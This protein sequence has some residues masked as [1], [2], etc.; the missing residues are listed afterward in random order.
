[1]SLPLLL[2]ILFIII[3]ALALLVLWAICKAG[4]DAD[5]LSERVVAELRRANRESHP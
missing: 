5:D 1:M 2:A 4:G 3:S